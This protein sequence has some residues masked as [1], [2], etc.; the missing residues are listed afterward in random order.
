MSERE[1][2]PDYIVKDDAG[3]PVAIVEVKYKIR[4]ADRAFFYGQLEQYLRNSN[5][6]LVGP[7]TLVVDRDTIEIFRGTPG[8]TEPTRLSTSLL[9]AYD[10]EYSA[11]SEYESYIVRLMEL[12]LDD[13]AHHWRFDPAPA[14]DELPPALVEA[15][16]AA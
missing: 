6:G 9:S 15:L 13:V 1:F 16:R 11:R 10:T 3:V 4:D 12:W 8:L 5:R 2:R 7:F 14:E